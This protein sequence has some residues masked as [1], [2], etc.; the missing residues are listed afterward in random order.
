[1]G[2]HRSPLQIIPK[3][4]YLKALH[5]AGLLFCPSD[6]MQ[7]VFIVQLRYKK[8]GRPKVAHMLCYV[9]I[10]CFYFAFAEATKD[11]SSSSGI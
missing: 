11:L 8:S 2:E 3:A 7:M 6:K 4:T 10:N 1:M 5:F 9:M